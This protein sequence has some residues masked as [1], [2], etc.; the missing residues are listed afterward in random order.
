[1]E[2][3]NNTEKKSYLVHGMHCASCKVLIE[4]SVGELQG[5]RKANVN[6]GT[7]VLTVELDPNI[8][9]EEQL[10]KAV[11]SAGNYDISQYSHEHKHEHK[12]HEYKQ[13]K[14]KVIAIGLASLPF[15]LL[16]LSMLI[17]P[18]QDLI[19]MYEKPVLI[20]QFVLS[21][22]VIYLSRE[23]YTSAWAGFIKKRANMDLLIAIGTLTAYLYS[24]LTIFIPSLF[25]DH[26]EPYFEAAVFILFFI[27]LG[28]L[29]ETRSKGQTGAAIESL[30]KLAAKDAVIIENGVEKKLPIE[31]IKEGYIVLV[32]SG[33]KIPLDGEIVEGETYVDESMITGEPI[34]VLKKTGDKVVGA[35]INTSGYIKVKVTKIG[36]DTVLSQIIKM[37]EDAQATQAPIQRLADKISAVFVP[38]V[39]VIALLTLVFWLAFGSSLGIEEPIQFAV[40]T[41]ISVLI[42]ACPCA[43]GLATPTAVVVGTGEGAKRGILFKEAKALENADK[44]RYIAMDKTGTITL[45]KP[46][47][48]EFIKIGTIPNIENI[49]SSVEKKSSHPL[50]SAIVQYLQTENELNVSQ[51]EEVAGRGVRAM[52]NGDIVLIGSAKFVL[53]SDQKFNQQD[54]LDELKQKGYSVILCS[55][56]SN[57]EAIFAVGDKVKDTAAS[58]IALLKKFGIDPIMITGDN[59]ETGEIIAKSVG[60]NTVYAE[61]TPEEKSL[62]VEELQSLHKGSVVG[63]VGDGINDAPALAKSDIGIAMGNGTDVALNSGS[64]VLVGGNIGKIP[65]VITISKNTVK[66]IKQNLFWAFGY[67]VIFIPI[68]AGVLFPAFGLLLSPT[69]AGA[70]MALSS[71]SVVSNSLRLKRLIKN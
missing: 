30:I 23:I 70:A 69:F 10:K 48:Q 19:M 36:K 66:V 54:K 6:Y 34:P 4:K 33:E 53:E 26:T 9:N 39:I 56:N 65:E 24:T 45:G 55:V 15:L 11:N 32:K 58:S 27:M 41:F 63:F 20:A 43:L 28:R 22:V 46:S 59:K 29:L 1:M 18:L 16:M 52:V 25:G 21:S 40:Y 62:K 47:V 14:S 35:T 71:I 31:H 13:I 51:F 7:E 60:I 61:V 57:V 17:K 2:D 3:K 12:F 49:I 44:M 42:I 37:V 5:V 67:N 50:A 68:A 38:F 64:V 8:T